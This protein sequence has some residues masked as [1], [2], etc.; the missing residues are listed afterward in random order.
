ME[1]DRI[2][3]ECATIEAKEYM[4]VGLKKE[5]IYRNNKNWDPVNHPRGDSPLGRHL[6]GDLQ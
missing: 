6:R 2:L 1:A 5:S 3:K 4:N